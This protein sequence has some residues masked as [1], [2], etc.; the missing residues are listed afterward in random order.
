MNK[1]LYPKIRDMP[2]Y[3]TRVSAE[4]TEAQIKNLLKKY[5]IENQQWT[6]YEGRSV[7]KFQ[8]DTVVQGAKVK[9]MVMLEIPSIKGRVWNKNHYSIE[10]VPE[11][12][13][14]RIVYHALKSILETTKYGVF[15]L[16]HIL[17]SYILTQLPDGTIKQ[18]KDVLEDHPLMLTMSEE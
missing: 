17:M 5:G 12:Q 15:K 7:L 8:V 11:H 2:Y 1:E 16:E 9:K 18:V 10:D 4:R 13:K 14:L 3:Q 6:T